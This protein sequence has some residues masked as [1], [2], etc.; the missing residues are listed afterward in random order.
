MPSQPSMPF[1]RTEASPEDEDA[2]LVA[3]IVAAYRL[4]IATPLGSPDSFW[5]TIFS[6]LKREI[7]DALLSDDPRVIQA[8]L[9][10]PSRSDLLYGFDN[11]AKSLLPNPADPPAHASEIYSLLVQL[12]EAVGGRAARCPEYPLKV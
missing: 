11:L 9:R 1:G 10:D 2:S 8:L 7:H 3:R 12:S 5:L 6:D 4:A